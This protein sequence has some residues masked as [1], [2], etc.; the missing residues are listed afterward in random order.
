MVDYLE[1]LEEKL[2]V[3]FQDNLDNDD[4]LSI[5]IY[6]EQSDDITTYELIDGYLS[7]CE[8]VKNCYKEFFD[9]LSSNAM[10]SKVCVLMKSM[11]IADVRECNG[12]Y[13]FNLSA[14]TPV[15]ISIELK[16]EEANYNNEKDKTYVLENDELTYDLSIDPSLKNNYREIVV[17]GMFSK[18]ANLNSLYDLLGQL[19]DVNRKLIYTT[20]AEKSLPISVELSNF[21]DV[22]IYYMGAN[23]RV[24]ILDVNLS[25]YKMKMDY[26]L[27]TRSSRDFL[28]NF[29][30]YNSVADP[31][32]VLNNSYINVSDIS[33]PNLRYNVRCS[34]QIL[35]EIFKANGYKHSLSYQNA[36]YN[37][38]ALYYVYG[39]NNV[40]EQVEDYEKVKVTDECYKFTFSDKSSIS[41]PK[42]KVVVIVEDD[43]CYRE[44][45]SEAV[46][47]L[48]K[49]MGY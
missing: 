8:D 41:Y 4:L 7:L 14:K 27:T 28:T 35:D 40:L 17:A 21:G 47:S 49:K 31:I 5:L 29:S 15:P 18:C 9:E 26:G 37:D 1:Y 44:C 42:S 24:C 20:H 12:G 11:N 46:K 34:G 3:N 23:D 36:H 39:E 32:W 22:S 2:G 45:E 33:I 30:R 38:Q 48:N 19:Y 43:D 6:E 10:D 13:L 25:G 16:I